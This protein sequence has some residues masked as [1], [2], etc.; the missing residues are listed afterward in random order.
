MIT[1]TMYLSAGEFCKGFTIKG[2]ADSYVGDSQYDLV[3]AA[4]SAVTLTCALGLRD[5][6][7]KQGTYDSENGFMSVNIAD[8]ADE[9]S[10]L[11]VK[12]ML[13]GLKMIQEG[14]KELQSIVQEKY[15]DTI[16]LINVKG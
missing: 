14:G 3:C 1:V 5:I 12:T 16:K 15:P 13:Q 6:L 9:Q 7:G 2:H 10:E 4:V 11:L 8:K